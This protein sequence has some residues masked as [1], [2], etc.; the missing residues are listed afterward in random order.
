MMARM[1][2]VALCSL[3]RAAGR[4]CE[5]H[6]A[7]EPVLQHLSLGSCS[8]IWPFSSSSS[9]GPSSSP[10]HP[11]P[12]EPHEQ[13]SP[14]Q[15]AP[16]QDTPQSAATSSSTAVPSMSHQRESQ[17]AQ[18]F[19]TAELYTDA[20]ANVPLKSAQYASSLDDP[21]GVQRNWFTALYKQLNYIA[22]TGQVKTI[23]GR[24]K[25]VFQQ[26]EAE[27]EHLYNKYVKDKPLQPG[28][29][30]SM[31]MCCLA[32]ATYRV[33]NDEIEDTRLVR[34]VIRTNLGSMMISLLQPIHRFKLWVLRHIL[35]EDMYHQAVGLLPAMLQG[36]GGPVES[37]RQ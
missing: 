12:S 33:L 13:S 21:F 5:H 11:S 15:A 34:E 7:H 3:A 16:A 37:K 10:Q 24:Q 1:G 23:V 27:F 32:V 25:E 31:L 36:M 28:D 29:H 6:A 2:K 8:S 17:P 30:R 19:S 9:S 4:G 35:R 20:N 18:V 14:P 22:K 26:V